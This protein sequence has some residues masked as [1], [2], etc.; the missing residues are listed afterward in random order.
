MSDLKKIEGLWHIIIK[1]WGV[2]EHSEE[3]LF[4]LAKSSDEAWNKLIKI[5]EQRNAKEFSCL[6]YDGKRVE[7]GDDTGDNGDVEIEQVAAKLINLI[8]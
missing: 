4:V 5:I 3:S 6:C 2:D 8:D 7:I 1:T